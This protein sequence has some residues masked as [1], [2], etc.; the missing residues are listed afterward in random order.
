VL[1][2]RGNAFGEL[3]E[4]KRTLAGSKLLSD[5]PHSLEG[6]TAA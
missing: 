3:T 6:D 4:A 2:C 1:E 5:L